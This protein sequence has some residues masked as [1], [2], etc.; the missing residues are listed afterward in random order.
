MSTRH[1]AALLMVV[2]VGCLPA[3][4]GGSAGSNSATTSGP[5][6]SD[7]DAQAIGSA[8]LAV[9]SSANASSYIVGHPE[10][11]RRAEQIL[12]PLIVAKALQVKPTSQLTSGL[13]TGLIDQLD[14]TT[15]G[16]TTGVGG[17]E[18]L[19]GPAVHRLLLFGLKDP[20]EVFR[21]KA[22]A[23]VTRL[24]RLLHGLTA[25]TRV[26]PAG[27]VPAETASKLATRDAQ[28]TSRYWPDLAGRLR[29]LA[30]SL[31]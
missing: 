26:S 31:G 5:A 21:P 29:D 11:V 12:N 4:C 30:G 6:V 24:E 16:L 27:V 9:F 20:A 25:N 10:N 19:D 3:A 28:V 18:R 23:G 17:E 14:N 8:D 7:T 15:P 1:A 13:V 2:A 22:A